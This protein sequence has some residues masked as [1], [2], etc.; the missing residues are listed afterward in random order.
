MSDIKLTEKP[1][2]F[3]ANMAKLLR[4]LGSRGDV[5][6]VKCKIEVVFSS[7]S[8]N[9]SDKKIAQY[10]HELSRKNTFLDVVKWVSDKALAG[11]GLTVIK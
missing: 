11:D 9:I 5:D 8:C 3:S 6:I 1:K 2:S 10:K 7:K 4:E